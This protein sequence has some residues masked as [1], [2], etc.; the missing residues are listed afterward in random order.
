MT[1]I[2]VLLPDG[3]MLWSVIV[4]LTGAPK[5][6]PVVGPLLLCGMQLGVLGSAISIVCE[7]Y[8]WPRG[9]VVYTAARIL[10]NDREINKYLKNTKL[11]VLLLKIN[12]GY[13]ETLRWPY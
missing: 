4:V 7:L 9:A 10:R 12:L 2:G 8:P 13:I 1:L 11:G 3:I 6:G 5:S